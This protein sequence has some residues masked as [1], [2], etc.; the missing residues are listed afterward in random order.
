MRKLSAD[1]IFPIYK[2]PIKNGILLVNE[3]G[4]I[5][6][7]V[8]NPETI[9]YTIDD[10]EYHSG[11]ICP[12]F[13]NTHCHLELSY[14]KDQ[15][16]KHSGLNGFIKEIEHIRKNANELTMEKAMINAENEMIHNGIVAIGDISNNNASFKIKNNSRLYYHTFIEA[17]AS[18]SKKAKF[19][20]E[21]ATTLYNEIRA[22]SKNRMASITPH[23]PYSLSKDLFCS[24]KDFSEKSENILSIH[25]QESETENE[26]FL[27]KQK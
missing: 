9:D 18:D 22:N 16:P 8:I 3:S 12:G 7:E 15:I 21:K 17:F 10:V 14:L 23:A 26:F 6:E 2:P 19:V 5:M 20:F 13:I 24:I 4:T 25:H 1:Y 27:K 11:F